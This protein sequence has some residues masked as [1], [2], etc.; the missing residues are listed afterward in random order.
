MFYVYSLIRQIKELIQ[1]VAITNAQNIESP[2]LTSR[3]IGGMEKRA[4]SLV[5]KIAILCKIL[6]RNIYI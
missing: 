1:K 5:K 4:M 6:Y 3:A 2:S